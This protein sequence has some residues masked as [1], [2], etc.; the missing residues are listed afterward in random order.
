MFHS[1][2]PDADGAVVMKEPGEE[3][4]KKHNKRYVSNPLATHPDELSFGDIYRHQPVVS[5]VIDPIL[6]RKL[7]PHQVEG[8]KFMYECVMGM[9]G[10]D[11]K[12]CILAD[13]MYVVHCILLYGA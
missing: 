8:V 13:E 1:H 9:R 5:V 2:D 11:G 12:G 4:H 6:A 3:Y 7:R 10:H